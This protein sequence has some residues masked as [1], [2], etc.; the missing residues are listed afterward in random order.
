VPAADAIALVQAPLWGLGRTCAAELP[1]LWGGLI[2]LDPDAPAGEA[3]DH[4]VRSL[5]S[6]DK[7]DQTAFRRGER[8]VMRVERVDAP[9]PRPFVLR[10]GASYLV[11]GGRSGLGLEVGRWLA[12][13]GASD[14]VLAGR[15]PVPPRETWGELPDDHPQAELIRIV[16]KL[17]E[18]GSCV[19][20]PALDVSDDRQLTDF[21]AR[22]AAEGHP[23]IRGVF[24]AAS[25]WRDA[26]GRSLVVPIAQMDLASVQEVCAPKV[27]GSWLL[28]RLLGVSLDFLVLFSSGASIVGSPGQGVYAAA[29]AFLDA[30]AHDMTRRSGPRTIAVNWGPITGTGFAM[31]PEGRTLVGVWERRGIGGIS[32]E[33]MLDTLRCVIPHSMPQLGVMKT[34]WVR[35]TQTYGELLSAPWASRLVRIQLGE[36]EDLLRALERAAPEERKDILVDALRRQVCIVMGL[37]PEDAPEPHQGFFELGIDSLLSL[38]LRNRVLHLVKRDFPA[39]AVFDHPTVDALA[40]YL[41]REVL[42]VETAAGG[43]GSM[44]P[45]SASDDEDVLALIEAMSDDEVRARLQHRARNAG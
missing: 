10:T 35:L 17:Q 9:E 38:E 7:E 37:R 6:G 33:Q 19:H 36:E 27:I 14:L 22:H 39:T 16:R 41:L 32:P 45:M 43:A 42:A 5:L 30:L 12:R 28:H 3:A 34:D 25:V 21:L 24:H 15:T 13:N 26:G 11:T 4:I 20:L 1:A 23:P 31:T 8:Y 44:R 2:D 18:L 40:D 29:N